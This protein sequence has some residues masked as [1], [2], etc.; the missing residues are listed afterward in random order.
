MMQILH[1]QPATTFQI[2]NRKCA[3]K[4]KKEKISH[5]FAVHFSLLLLPARIAFVFD[6]KV[7]FILET[8]NWTLREDQLAQCSSIKYP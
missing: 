2:K 7:S 1:T 8:K 4:R 3:K 5:E 6:N